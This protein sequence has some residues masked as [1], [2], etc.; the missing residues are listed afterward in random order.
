MSID[1]GSLMECY[2]Q[3]TL[4][5]DLGYITSEELESIRGKFEEI[6]KMLSGFRKYLLTL[7]VPPHP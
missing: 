1:Y 6:G 5:M 4:A 2:C 3:L 7:T